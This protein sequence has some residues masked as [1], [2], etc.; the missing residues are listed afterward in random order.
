MKALF[1]VLITLSLAVS[2]NALLQ[3]VD[4]Y[5][6]DPQTL[7]GITTTDTITLEHEGTDYS[8]YVQSLT[9]DAATL[10][11]SSEGSTTPPEK[12]SIVLNDAVEQDINKDL[13]PDLVIKFNSMENRKASFTMASIAQAPKVIQEPQPKDDKLTPEEEE[14]ANQ[15]ASAFLQYA[16]QLTSGVLLITGKATLFSTATSYGI[17]LG[18]QELSK[19]DPNAGVAYSAFNAIKGLGSAA[20]PAPESSPEPAVTGQAILQQVG[21]AFLLAGFDGRNMYYNFALKPQYSKDTS[22][23]FRAAQM[24]AK[25]IVVKKDFSDENIDIS[26]LPAGFFTLQSSLFHR[27]NG[28][29]ELSPLNGAIRKADLA[30]EKGTVL[31]F[32]NLQE[33]PF[34]AR[35][36]K[37]SSLIF[38]A[39]KKEVSAENTGIT[40]S[41][42]DNTVRIQNTLLITS[43]TT[44]H[45]ATTPQQQDHAQLQSSVGKVE[46]FLEKTLSPTLEITTQQPLSLEQASERLVFTPRTDATLIAEG[47]AMVAS[48]LSESGT[49]TIDT[50]AAPV[51]RDENN[52]VRITTLA[53]QLRNYELIKNIASPAVKATL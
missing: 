53:D 26:F 18:I 8:L 14:Q 37:D 23:L 45:I 21:N 25:D 5:A 47:G 39:E 31:D 10:L 16:P 4:I 29:I 52:E 15:A 42:R 27:V 51:I 43:S 36:E 33:Q 7:Y 9:E 24:R 20:A 6:P 19:D 30:S 50:T 2:A 48:L 38:D 40:L 11:L 41:N 28:N 34:S 13:Q 44:L 1:L 49:L 22:F 3:S 32:A 46:F 17:Q 12:I 35:L